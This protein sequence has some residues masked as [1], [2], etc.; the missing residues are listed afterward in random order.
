MSCK[1]WDPLIPSVTRYHAHIHPSAALAAVI[2]LRTCAEGWGIYIDD[3]LI[4]GTEE[5][6]R[7]AWNYSYLGVF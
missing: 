2:I 3:E 6:F 7:G 5:T 4:A 1:R